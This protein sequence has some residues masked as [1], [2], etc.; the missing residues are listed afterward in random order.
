MKQRST[1]RRGKK[2]KSKN[3][4]RKIAVHAMMALE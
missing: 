3:K 4:E 2:L 1:C